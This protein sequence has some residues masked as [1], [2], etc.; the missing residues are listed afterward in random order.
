MLRRQE[1][2]AHRARVAR[3]Q[4]AGSSAR[5]A[6][7]RPGGVAVEAEDHRVGE[8]EQLL[9]V[10]GR[11]GRAQRGHGIAEAALRQRDD[12]HV[13]LDHQHVAALPDRAAAFVRGRRALR[14]C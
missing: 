2:E 4:Q 6:A 10:F 12:V 13:A 11:A 8:A 1:Q 3:M 9:H 14:P 5:P 7:R